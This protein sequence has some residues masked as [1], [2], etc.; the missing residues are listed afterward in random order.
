MGKK[1]DFWFASFEWY[2]SCDIFWFLDQWL[3]DGV[4][5][6]I[7]NRTKLQAIRYL[8]KAKNQRNGH[9]GGDW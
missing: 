1:Y 2:A 8:G 9:R 3:Y 5:E 7:R 4:C 6:R